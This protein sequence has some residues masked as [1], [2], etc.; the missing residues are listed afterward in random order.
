[1]QHR[2]AGGAGAASAIILV[3]KIEIVDLRCFK[4]GF[5]Q[6]I[7]GGGEFLKWESKEGRGM[8]ECPHSYH[9]LCFCTDE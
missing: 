1:M 9:A 3:L 6:E 5:Q 8:E 2:P 7:G 4:G